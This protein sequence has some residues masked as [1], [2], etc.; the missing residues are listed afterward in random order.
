MKPDEQVMLPLPGDYR[1]LLERLVA[2]GYECRT[3]HNAEPDR[4]HLV[5][6]HDIDISVS[7]AYRIAELEAELSFQASYFVLLRNEFYN[8]FSAESSRQLR[9]MIEMGHEIGLHV[10]YSLYKGTD[11]SLHEAVVQESR[12]LSDILEVPIALVSFHRPATHLAGQDYDALRL[13]GFRHT[14]ER[15]FF[16]EMGFCSD[17]RGGWYHGHPLD[18][19]AVKEGRG[20]QLLTHPIWWTKPGLANARERLNDFLEEKRLRLLQELRSN[21]RILRSDN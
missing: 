16:S 6:R 7:D 15:R 18:H 9:A 8:V 4:K 2:L 14:Y 20:L 1:E 19:A 10:D 21:F 11:K 3:F 5:L 13:P 12:V 17:S